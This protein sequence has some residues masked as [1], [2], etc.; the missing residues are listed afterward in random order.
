MTIQELK[1]VSIVNFLSTLGFQ[2]EH[3]RLNGNEYWYKSPIRNE[4]TAS[5]KVTVEKNTW[6]DFGLGAGGSIIDL[7]MKL[8]SCDVK[9]SIEFLK[10]HLNIL[11]P[12][13]AGRKLPSK[14]DGSIAELRSI[15]DL[16][17]P[18]LCEFLTSRGIDLEIAGV[19]IKEVYYRRNNKNYFTVGMEN[20][21]GG[22][23]IRTKLFK[24]CLFSKDMT[25]IKADYKSVS[26]F[27]GF[28][29]FLSLLTLQKINAL[30]SDVIILHSTSLMQ[31]AIDQIVLSEYQKVYAFLDNDTAG[32]EAL[33]K[34]NMC[35][36]LA[37]K[38]M[39]YL[40]KEHNDINDFL[41]SKLSH[42]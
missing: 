19:Y 1:A 41:I 27:E 6:Y 12:Y 24:G 11:T 42:L 37:V 20:D 17:N 4:K 38:D 33:S 10:A 21:S 29:D 35:K 18:A 39:R 14:G 9:A 16:N 32:D 28:I 23:E 13:N 40:Y 7:I 30:K 5:F 34:I 15:K 25:S 3:S 8:K 26:I 2:P 22:Y 31:K 36:D